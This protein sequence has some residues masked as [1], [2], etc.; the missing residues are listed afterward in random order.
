MIMTKI[1]MSILSISQE[2]DKEGNI[3]YPPKQTILFSKAHKFSAI[4]IKPHFL[5]KPY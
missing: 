3:F 5:A 1:Q 2:H 4:E